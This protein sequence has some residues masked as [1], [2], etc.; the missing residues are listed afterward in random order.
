[1]DKQS[2]ILVTTALETLDE[3]AKKEGLLAGANSLMIDITPKD[4]VRLYSIYD[5]RAGIDKDIAKT[6][7][8]TVEL[9]YSIGRAPTDLGI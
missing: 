7:K 2:K 9:L 1:M 5:N 4:Y 3:K 6:I 8:E